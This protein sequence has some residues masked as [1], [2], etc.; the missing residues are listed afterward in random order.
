VCEVD[1]AVTNK[2]LVQK[3]PYGSIASSTSLNRYKNIDGEALFEGNNEVK[4]V[5]YSIPADLASTLDTFIKKYYSKSV[6]VKNST[7]C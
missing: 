2:Y 6:A 5:D 1:F 4:A 3:S 7:A